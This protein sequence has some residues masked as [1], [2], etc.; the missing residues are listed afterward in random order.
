MKDER[1]PDLDGLIREARHWRVGPALHSGLVLTR[2]FS[3]PSL[4]GPGLPGILR[5]PSRAVNISCW[6]G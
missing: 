3:S 5:P 4:R 6:P 1:F 2:P